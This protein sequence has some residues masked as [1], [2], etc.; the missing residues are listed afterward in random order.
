MINIDN[1]ETLLLEVIYGCNKLVLDKSLM[2]ICNKYQID[3][4]KIT[5]ES[6][7]SLELENKLK[8]KFF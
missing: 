8:E 1:L 5:F 3:S 6:Q 4:N 2:N 7:L